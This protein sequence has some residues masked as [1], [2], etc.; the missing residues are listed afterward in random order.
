M[1]QIKNSPGANLPLSR[2]TP[3]RNQPAQTPIG[4]SSPQAPATPAQSTVHQPGSSPDGAAWGNFLGQNGA[5]RVSVNV[6]GPGLNQGQQ[7]VIR[8][9]IQN[10]LGV[11][12]VQPSPIYNYGSYQTTGHA[13]LD[14]RLDSMVD[15]LL[16][17]PRESGGLG[18]PSQNI[19][20][21]FHLDLGAD[22][23]VGSLADNPYSADSPLLHS[24]GTKGQTLGEIGGALVNTGGSFYQPTPLGNLSG[25]G[26]VTALA[27]RARAYG[28][29]DPA[30]LAAEFG[31]EADL[32]LLEA[33]GSMTMEQNML[34]LGFLQAGQRTSVDGRVYAGAQAWADARVSLANGPRAT[35]SAGAFAGASAELAA[36]QDFVV[37]GRSLVGAHGAVKAWAGAGAKLELDVGIENG[38]LDFRFD[39]GAAL[40]V[41]I[42]VDFGFSIDF[43]A[44]A[45]TVKDVVKGVV[46]SVLDVLSGGFL[47][48]MGSDSELLAAQVEAL[49]AERL[50]EIFRA[51]DYSDAYQ[52]SDDYAVA[53]F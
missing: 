50:L 8:Q 35:V 20:D 4:P 17:D 53:E 49:A 45:D 27:A 46:G 6:T 29:V 9:Q 40:G 43:K 42:E 24:Y 22:A 15:K 33:R 32:T 3:A 37:N 11:G 1:S 18:L 5:P 26:Y 47:G 34:D 44:M 25:S 51:A 14:A 48:A 13:G 52:M 16:F 12:T 7:S 30:A 39:I 38:K 19:S 10:A 21:S 31:V 36:S 28:S 41:G 2:Q 23:A